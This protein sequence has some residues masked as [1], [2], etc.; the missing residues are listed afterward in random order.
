[1]KSLKNNALRFTAIMFF[2]GMLTL[3]TNIYAQE[4]DE[5]IIDTNIVWVNASGHQWRTS[6]CFGDTS[7]FAVWEDSWIVL[8]EVEDKNLGICGTR[9]SRSPMDTPVLDPARIVISTIGIAVHSPAIAFDGTNYL[10]VWD[11]HR[12]SQGYNND[13]YGAR[14]SQSGEVLDTAG[15]DIATAAGHQKAASVCF[16]DTNYLVVWV[17]RN[18]NDIYATRVS[19]SG[20]VLDPDGIFISTTAYQLSFPT[21]AFD[22]TNWLVVWDDGEYVYGTRVSQSGDVLDPEGIVV[23]G[24]ITPDVAFDGTNYLVVY[25]AWGIYGTRVDTSGTVL[26]PGGFRIS[27]GTPGMQ[28][29]PSI[30]FNGTNYLVAWEDW[31]EEMVFADIYGAMVSP[32][33]EVLNPA[34]IPIAIAYGSNQRSP[35]VASEGSDWLVLWENNRGYPVKD[36]CG[37]R[38]DSLG[39]VLNPEP[40][41]ITISTGGNDQ[42]HSSVA[43]NGTNYLVAWCEWYGTSE[44]WRNIYGT[45]VDPF[46]VTLDT[47]SIAISTHTG[48]CQMRT[49]ATSD[50]TNYFVTWTDLH[51]GQQYVI[52]GARVNEAGQVLDPDGITISGGKISSVCFGGG[53]YFVVCGGYQS[54]SGVRISQSGVILD[55]EPIY[56]EDYSGYDPSPSVCFDG[57]NFF[58]VWAGQGY[59][60]RGAWISPSGELLDNIDIAASGYFPVVSFDGT[61]YLV[62]WRY[63]RNEFD[64]DIYGARVSQSGEVLDPDGI[65]IS[66]EGMSPAVSFDGSN[67]VVVWDTRQPREND[68]EIY[69]ALV[70]PSG[71][72]IDSLEICT[73]PGEQFSPDL[74]RGTEEQ[75]L[76]IWRGWTPTIN[77]QPANTYRIWG[78]LYPFIVAIDEEFVSGTEAFRLYQNYPNPFS[79]STTISFNIHRRDTKDAEITIYNVKGQLVKTLTPM[80]NDKCLMTNVVWDGKDENGKQLSSGIYFYQLETQTQK[81]KYLSTRKMILLR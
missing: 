36:I 58:A 68:S 27:I 4:N 43:F 11:D 48:V 50:G 66:T 47:T 37:S 5:F 25:T 9:V 7:Y 20:E 51:D 70:S 18:D 75:V 15:I 61:N 2:I 8:D 79:T 23:S 45:R 19:P 64:Y 31:L 10:V 44:H 39:T 46:G 76:I 30:S 71:V 77:N 74:T 28:I 34:D 6:I 17:D 80:T 59:T 14:I 35:A 53:V 67:F 54:V 69:G 32:S 72:V 40:N 26:D 21:V 49:S 81:G 24:G 12:N 65:V 52:C 62:V 42:A 56:I 33:G 55:P 1:M 29:F 73:Q 57:T 22:G 38:I 41:S 63:R 13:I 16:G 3:V 78:R 60:V